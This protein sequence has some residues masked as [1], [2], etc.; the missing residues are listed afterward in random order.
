MEI[1]CD[2]DYTLAAEKWA[3]EARRFALNTPYIL[4]GVR[5]PRDGD[6]KAKPYNLGYDVEYGKAMAKKMGALT[7]LECDV[8]SLQGVKQV[9]DEVRIS[10]YHNQRHYANALGKAILTAL[11]PPDPPV[12]DKQK[13]A[14]RWGRSKSKDSAPLTSGM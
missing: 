7:Y 6:E 5:C 12:L 9:F 10:F 8:F 11:N 13:K 3:P 2:D 14:S 1:G 4:V